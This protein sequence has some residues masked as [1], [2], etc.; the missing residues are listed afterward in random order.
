M[1]DS[2]DPASIAR[3]LA[4]LDISEVEEQAYRG[5]VGRPGATVA[6]L[7]SALGMST[8]R[9]QRLLD[10]L[11]AKGLA[12]H[13]P[14]RPRR[15]IPAAPDLAIERLIMQR[16]EELE[17]AR[18][19]IGDL[20]VEGESARS[21]GGP[22][23]FVEI[24]SSREAERQVL[25]DSIRAAR[26]SVLSLVRPPVRVSRLDIPR[27]QDQRLQLQARDRGVHFRTVVDADFLELPGTADAVRA[28]IQA[29]EEVR[30]AVQ[31]PVKL[32]IVDT[33]V[34]LLPLDLQKP[35]SPALLVRPSP[36][37]DALRLL[38]EQIWERASPMSFACE[39]GSNNAD[40][41]TRLSASDE[42]A[43]LLA[44]G[45]SDKV[46][47]RE[48][49]VSLRTLERR[50]AALMNELGARTRFQS[51]WLAALRLGAEDRS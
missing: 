39:S 9:I 4:P 49:G 25:D 44:A 32:V 14:Q 29:G 40:V 2:R 12:T 34:G 11:E 48:L 8:R 33:R 23:R 47:A 16:Q 31:L 3:P 22:D 41:A 20:Q 15:Y 19:V 37:L 42:L 6:E 50:I 36:L 43:R 38:Y 13:T 45:L 10:V 1:T 18:S 30:V 46:I 21:G 17:R 28:D 27:N 35:D 24:I 26:E 7:A 51:G 5:L